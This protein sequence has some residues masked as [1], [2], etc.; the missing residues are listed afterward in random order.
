MLSPEEVA[1][2]KQEMEMKRIET[3]R[4]ARRR[5]PFALI[6]GI[7]ALVLMIG[8]AII[9]TGWGPGESSRGQLTLSG[10]TS[11]SWELTGEYD[12]GRTDTIILVSVPIPRIAKEVQGVLS[13]PRDT[14]VMIPGRGVGIGLTTH[15]ALA[16]P[17]AGQED[18]GE[19][20]RDRHHDYYVV[21][22]FCRVH[23]DISLQRLAEWRSTSK[24]GCGIKIGSRDCISTCT[25][26]DKV[27]DG[28]QALN[29]IR[30]R[31]R[32]L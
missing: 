24:S 32:W 8:T 31:A 20:A 9:A 29:Y 18:G 3:G 10:P 17:P 21:V 7:V 14:R 26:D 22:D 6:V 15:Y 25:R 16:G 23:E 4:L 2:K 11:S 19:L 28:W 13:V 27:L 30:Y 12:P 1:Q 5:S